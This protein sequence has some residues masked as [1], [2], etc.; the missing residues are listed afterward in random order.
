MRDERDRAVVVFG[1]HLQRRRA[2]VERQALH[3]CEVGGGGLLVA[4]HD[5]GATDEDVGARRDRP[6]ALPAGQ[7]VRSDV[8]GEVDTAIAKRA[9]RLE[10][11]AGDV[12]DDGPR[13]QGQ[14]PLDDVGG[15]IRR[16]R[17]DDQ[18]RV[19]VISRA[20]SGAVVDREAQLRGRRVVEGDVDPASSQ[21][22]PDARPEKT[23]ADDADRALHAGSE[24]TRGA[25][26]RACRFAHSFSW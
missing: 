23:G 12:G 5:P 26:R 13:I 22:V 7:R 2:E 4:A 24:R 15:D 17:H 14:F 6:A 8:V 9:Q 16:Y 1:R 3:Q 11:D 19:V 21:R 10:L 18:R 20:P 25:R